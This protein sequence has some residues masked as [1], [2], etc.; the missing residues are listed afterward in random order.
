MPAT[1]E[2]TG[3][4]ALPLVASNPSCLII[5]S[6]GRAAAVRWG[7]LVQGDIRDRDRLQSAITL[8]QPDSIIHFAAF[9]YV[10]ESVADPAKYCRNNVSGTL[11][12]LEAM[13][14]SG[15][16]KLVF[17][18]SCATYGVPERLRISEDTLQAPISPYGRTS[19][20][21][22]IA[23]RYF[24]AAGADPDGEIGERH[25][26]ETHLIPRAL[27]AAAGL[28]PAL[29]VFGDNYP[30]ADGSCVRD[31]VHV[32]DLAEGHVRACP[33]GRG[34]G[35]RQHEAGDRAGHVHPAAASC[36]R[37]GGQTEGTGDHATPAR[38]R[39]AGDLGGRFSGKDAAGVQ[40]R[41]LRHGHD[42]PHGVGVSDS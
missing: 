10:G 15:L 25:D 32:T 39:S 27:L 34:R 17:S 12:L 19:G 38:G 42:Y 1:S 3:V 9:A 7:P 6:R 35:E 4:S 37:P 20:L 30:T 11:T 31:Y 16:G 5:F 33:P 24:N 22:S 8:F 13:H 26:P 18:S 14:A 28:I 23:L 36:H 2:V 29:E 40:S 21:R 41:A